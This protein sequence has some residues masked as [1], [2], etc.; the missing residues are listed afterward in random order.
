MNSFA[1]IADWNVFW[2][3]DFCRLHT[4]IILCNF[5]CL[6][7]FVQKNCNSVFSCFVKYII[8]ANVT[9]K[10][11]KICCVGVVTVKRE[12]QVRKAS[13]CASKQ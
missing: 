3:V 7:Y 2:Y 1:S 9:C 11:L 12:W 10:F 5:K 13:H 4:A 6:L 8:F